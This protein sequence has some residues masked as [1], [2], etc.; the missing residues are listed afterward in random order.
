MRILILQQ[1]K[2]FKTNKIAVQWAQIYRVL[3]ESKIYKHFG[4]WNTLRR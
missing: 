3:D 2:T 4:Y 1:Y